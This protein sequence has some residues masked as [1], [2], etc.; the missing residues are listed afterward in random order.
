MSDFVAEDA[1][2]YFLMNCRRITRVL[3]GLALGVG[4][5]NGLSA[6]HTDMWNQPKYKP[7]AASTF[8]PDG[9]AAR[10]PVPGTIPYEGIRRSWTNPLYQELTQQPQVPAFNDEAFYTG[11]LGANFV[12]DNY[13]PITEQLLQ[14]GK[15]RF[16]ITCAP[17]HGLVGDGNGVVT[18][19]GFPMPPTFHQ[20]RLREVEDGYIFDVITRGFGRMYTYA[21]RVAPEDRWAIIAYIRAL[22]YSQNVPLDQLTAEEREKALHPELQEQPQGEKAATH[23]H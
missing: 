17:C 15:E 7:L 3:L 18:S 19:R 23:A 8:F 1:G 5:L 11:K 20:D 16:E 22:Q 13:F 9:A 12:A 21:A 10:M 14:R 2:D 4:L 6:C